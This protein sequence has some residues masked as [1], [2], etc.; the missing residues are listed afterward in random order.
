MWIEIARYWCNFSVELIIMWSLEVSFGQKARPG[1]EPRIRAGLKYWARS[2]SG[3]SNAGP[4]SGFAFG[5]KRTWSPKPNP[6]PNPQSLMWGGELGVKQHCPPVM[7]VG[8]APATG[9][10]SCWRYTVSLLVVWFVKP[11]VTLNTI[12]Y[13]VE[14]SEAVCPR[15]SSAL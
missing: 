1:T 10:I 7:L 14:R 3:F 4:G 11:T 5:P 2:G 13:I 12:V 15:P 6:C 9:E 8:I